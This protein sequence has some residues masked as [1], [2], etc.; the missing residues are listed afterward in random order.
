MH[1][2]KVVRGYPGHPGWLLLGAYQACRAACSPVPWGK[3]CRAWERSVL[4]PGT[5]SF[6]RGPSPAISCHFMSPSCS[7]RTPPSLPKALPTGSI[8]LSCARPR[9]AWLPV[10]AGGAGAEPTSSTWPSSASAGIGTGSTM[11][12]G[13]AGTAGTSPRAGSGSASRWSPKQSQPNHAA[14]RYQGGL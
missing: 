12:S 11:A 10:G 8:C 5:A 9:A 7:P 3:L 1:P 2:G 4:P 13:T 6:V 14:W